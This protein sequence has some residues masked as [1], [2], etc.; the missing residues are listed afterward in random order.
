VRVM[1]VRWIEMLRIKWFDHWSIYPS[2]STAPVSLIWTRPPARSVRG[3][4]RYSRVVIRNE[5]KDPALCATD[6]TDFIV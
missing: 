1:R 3:H 5:V 6:H 2:G 4:A